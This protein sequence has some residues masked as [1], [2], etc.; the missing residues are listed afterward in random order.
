ML[1]EP[2]IP[3]LMQLGDTFWMGWTLAHESEH[4]MCVTVLMVRWFGKEENAVIMEPPNAN[5]WQ[6]AI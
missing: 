4:T 1:V 2:N 5:A 3:L 6:P